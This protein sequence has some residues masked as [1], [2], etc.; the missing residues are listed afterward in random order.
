MKTIAV[1]AAGLALF[2]TSAAYAQTTPPAGKTPPPA[3]TQEQPPAPDARTADRGMEGGHHGWRRHHARHHGERSGP[4]GAAFRL[5]HG[6]DGPS[7]SIRCADGDS[8]QA[9]VD[10]IMPMIE[11]LIP[12]HAGMSPG[13]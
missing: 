13:Q 7:L 12:P 2:I 3:V 6:D 11:R 5:S 9:C 1:A 10:A 4:R 8:T